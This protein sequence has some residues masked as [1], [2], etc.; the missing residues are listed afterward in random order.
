MESDEWR[1]L[2]GAVPDSSKPCSKCE[3]GIGH[4]PLETLNH[5]RNR[6]LSEWLIVPAWKF[7]IRRHQRILSPM[8]SWLRMSYRCHFC[9]DPLKPIHYSF[10]EFVFSLF[11]MRHYYCPHCF[12]VTLHTGGWLRFI[13]WPFLLIWRF[14]CWIFGG[15]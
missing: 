7:G 5:F 2:T 10:S 1:T 15:F 6:V 12:E 14:L 3:W 9:R 8:F 4:F 13:G 11:G